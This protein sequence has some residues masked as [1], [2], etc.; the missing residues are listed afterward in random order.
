[1]HDF[2]R[3]TAEHIRWPDN[4]RIADSAA[5]VKRLFLVTC[6]TVRWLFEFNGFDQFLKPLT[7][8]SQIN[9][10]GRSADNRCSGCFKFARQLQRRL[11]A[12]LHDHSFRFFDVYD[13][14][15]IFK[16]Q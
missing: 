8:F 16:S 3:A 4:E 5:P 9:R 12:V 6:R 7:V 10:I 14:H 11:A 15:D 1:M 2:H 13:L